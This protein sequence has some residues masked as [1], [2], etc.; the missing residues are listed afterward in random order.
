MTT[1]TREVGLKDLFQDF[2]HLRVEYVT[3]VH[4]LQFR[5]LPDEWVTNYAGFQH[6]MQEIYGLSEAEA[7]EIG[8]TL[9]RIGDR[10]IK[11]MAQEMTQTLKDSLCQVLADNGVPE[12]CLGCDAD[13]E[14][15]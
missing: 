8:K 3:N 7:M 4:K 6:R 2:T 11:T 5:L 14:E 10:H 12:I 9:A 1:V 13:P 15:D